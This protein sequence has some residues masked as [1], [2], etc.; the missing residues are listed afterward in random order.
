MKV[1][2]Q[3]PLCQAVTG[4]TEVLLKAAQAEVTSPRH[5]TDSAQHEQ[6]FS[7]VS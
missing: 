3:L 1:E 5:R 2:A 7:L 6:V 4:F